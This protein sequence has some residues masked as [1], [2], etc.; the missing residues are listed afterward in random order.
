MNKFIQFVKN[1]LNPDVKIFTVEDFYLLKRKGKYYFLCVTPESILSHKTKEVRVYKEWREGCKT[2]VFYRDIYFLARTDVKSR[3]E[4][5]FDIHA[6]VHLCRSSL[7]MAGMTIGGK[8]PDM[9]F[10]NE[11]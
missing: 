6:H 11:F 3:E 8:K 7:Q 4:Y 10:Y 2:L 9:I 1:I 5:D